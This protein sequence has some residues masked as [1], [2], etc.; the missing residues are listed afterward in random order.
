MDTQFWLERWSKGE[1]GFHHDEVHDLLATHWPPFKL[2]AGSDVFVPLC[3]KSHDMVW[4]AGL[5]HRVIGAE[6]SQIAVEAFFAERELAPSVR[7]AGAFKV[8]SAGPYEIWCGDMFAMPAEALS[9]VGGVYDRAAL[10][11]FEPAQQIA[12]GKKLTEVVPASAPMLL[13]ALEYPEGQIKGPPFSTP[14]FQIATIYGPT[15]RI[16]I[17]ESR[18]GLEQSQ[19]L[20][21]RG[22]TSLVETAYVLRRL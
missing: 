8:Y 4:L 21:A 15:H 19:N 14:L 17:A 18:D 1:I 9:N 11:A 16:A 6:L 7:E 12:Y 10:V 3:G 2:A 22:V 13:I 20:T 5:G